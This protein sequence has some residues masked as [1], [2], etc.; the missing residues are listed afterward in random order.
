MPRPS[1]A[2]IHNW[3]VYHPPTEVQIAKYLVLREKGKELANTIMLNCPESADRSVAIRK[4]REAIMTA[5]A[6]IA[7]F[8]E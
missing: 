1:E 8:E 7:C 5:N 3:F 6:S 2:E 4:V